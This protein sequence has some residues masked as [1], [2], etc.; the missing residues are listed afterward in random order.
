[1]WQDFY[2]WEGE[3]HQDF[4]FHPGESLVLSLAQLISDDRE[5]VHASSHEEVDQQKENDDDVAEN[6]NHPRPVQPSLK[7][8][9]SPSQIGDIDSVEKT[10]VPASTLLAGCSTRLGHPRTPGLTRWQT[11]VRDPRLGRL[12]HPTKSSSRSRHMSLERRRLTALQTLRIRTTC[13]GRGLAWS[14]R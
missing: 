14:L 4:P 5:G 9:I 2:K 13:C 12:S 11:L 7:V 8:P 6:K 10:P 3:K 1:M